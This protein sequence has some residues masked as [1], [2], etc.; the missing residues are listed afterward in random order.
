MAQRLVDAFDADGDVRVGA[1][2]H[3]AQRVGQTG[4]PS[5]VSEIKQRPVQRPGRVDRCATYRTRDQQCAK[6]LGEKIGVVGATTRCPAG[7]PSREGACEPERSLHRAVGLQSRL[8]HPALQR[9]HARRH[10]LVVISMKYSGPGDLF[11]VRGAR[12]V[13]PLQ[14]SH[15]LF[16]RG[17][18]LPLA[19]WVLQHDKRFVQSRPPRFGT[20]SASNIREELKR[21]VEA[22]MLHEDR[23]GDGRVWYERTDSTLWTVVQAAVEATGLVWDDDRMITTDAAD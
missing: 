17:C 1:R 4:V 2:L 19:A 8:D 10:L 21:L 22:G 13:N 7:P 15:L 6:Q 20:V 11:L 3:P 14:V 16:G 5:A 18:R 12:V 9:H 23:P